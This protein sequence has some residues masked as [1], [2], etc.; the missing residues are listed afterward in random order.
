MN[1]LKLAAFFILV[2]LNLSSN[3][4]ALAEYHPDDLETRTNE[5]LDSL[6]NVYGTPVDITFVSNGH[7]YEATLYLEDSE[8]KILDVYNRRRNRS[9]QF[10]YWQSVRKA[11][12]KK[13]FFILEN[14]PSSFIRWYIYSHILEKRLVPSNMEFL[15]AHLSDVESVE[16]LSRTREVYST[17]LIY[18]L[19]VDPK[20]TR[21]EQ[22]IFRNKRNEIAMKILDLNL[23]SP[24]MTDYALQR[25]GIVESNYDTIRHHAFK[26]NK[27]AERQLMRFKNEKDQ[28]FF[29]KK[30]SAI[31]MADTIVKD[32]NSLVRHMIQ[33][34]FPKVPPDVYVL[35]HDKAKA[36]GR[37]EQV[38]NEYSFMYRKL[39]SSRHPQRLRIV[40]DLLE[41]SFSEKFTDELLAYRITSLL[42][43]GYDH[44]GEF[45]ELRMSFWEEHG[46]LSRNTFYSLSTKFPER[47]IPLAI[48]ELDLLVTDQFKKVGDFRSF[49][50]A[51]RENKIPTEKYIDLALKSENH[52]LNETALGTL[53]KNP[54]LSAKSYLFDLLET[55][56]FVHVDDKILKLLD[57]YALTSVEKNRVKEWYLSAIADMGTTNRKYYLEIL[58]DMDITF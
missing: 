48:K 28:D 1:N 57:T 46:I 23:E 49:I 44:K 6:F 5:I 32:H 36:S 31:L 30:I 53:G 42:G 19:I 34:N 14:H 43:S 58:Q 39:I 47:A 56:T 21:E 15:L 4:Q 2:S 11:I 18:K 45:S 52:R 22:K 20:L 29:A 8:K 3:A 40:N 26:G 51:L 13:D 9:D 33:H 25:L 54:H 10:K 24:A 55:P 7:S 35:V 12:P 38:L 37:L 27:I 50:R 41:T 16:L 17:P